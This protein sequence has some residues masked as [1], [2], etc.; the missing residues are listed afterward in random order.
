MA[1]VVAVSVMLVVSVEE[2][3]LPSVVEVAV[4]SLVVVDG[5]PFWV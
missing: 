4:V 5:V 3:I 1:E 2:T